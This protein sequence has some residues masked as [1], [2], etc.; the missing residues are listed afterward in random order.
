MRPGRRC[1]SAGPVTKDLSA[2]QPGCPLLPGTA[3]IEP[4]GGGTGF[5]FKIRNVQIDGRGTR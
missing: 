4:F 2:G 5:R 3:M 1:P